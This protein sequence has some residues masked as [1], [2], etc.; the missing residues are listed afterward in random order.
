[1]YTEKY[2]LLY[3]EIKNIYNSYMDFKVK[4]TINIIANKITI[5]YIKHIIIK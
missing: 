2:I 5:I 4:L 1:M 3:M